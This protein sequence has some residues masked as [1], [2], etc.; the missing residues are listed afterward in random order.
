MR[1]IKEALGSIADKIKRAV[2]QILGSDKRDNDQDNFL[3][4]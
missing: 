1:S 3:F 4:V 2:K